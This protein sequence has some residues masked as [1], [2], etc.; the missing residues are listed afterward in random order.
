MELLTESLP[1]GFHGA[2]GC[3]FELL[4]GLDQLHEP[5][6]RRRSLGGP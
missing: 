1:L 2:E 4:L 5:E 3:G 6:K